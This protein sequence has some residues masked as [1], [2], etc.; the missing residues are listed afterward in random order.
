MW[1]VTADGSEYAWDGSAWEELGETVDLSGY[2]EED[3]TTIATTAQIDSLFAT[4][5]GGGGGA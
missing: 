2:V 1:H 5:S 3:D 4:Q